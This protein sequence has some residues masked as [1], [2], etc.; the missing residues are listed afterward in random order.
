MRSFIITL[1]LLISMISVI[2][3][4]AVYINATAEKIIELT[5]DANFKKAPIDAL[6]RLESFWDENKL[7]VE[8]SVGYKSTDRIS[9]L[10]I[11]LREYVITNNLTEA[12]RVR[13]LI[14]DCA[15]DISKL[16]KLS[17]ENLL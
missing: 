7:F 15:S 1:L 6:L 16:E 13:K 12:R 8:F 9:E 5:E 3:A 17:L 4:N 11:D 14:A 10:L 2:V